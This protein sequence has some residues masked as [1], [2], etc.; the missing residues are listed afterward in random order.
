MWGKLWMQVFSCFLP[1]T[2]T[3]SHDTKPKKNIF[4]CKSTVLKSQSLNEPHDSWQLLQSDTLK[5]DPQ[6]CEKNSFLNCQANS[7]QN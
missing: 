3:L 6:S 2:P 7:S 4:S 5:L 1:L